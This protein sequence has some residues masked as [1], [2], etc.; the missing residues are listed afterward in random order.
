MTQTGEVDLQSNTKKPCPN[1]DPNITQRAASDPA[2]SVWVGASAGTGKTKVLTD[3]VLR[4]LLPRHDGQEGTPA[5]RILCLTFTKAAANEM[6]IRIHETLARWAIMPIESNDGSKSL[7]AVI[8][9]LLGHRP[10]AEQLNAA[11]CLFAQVIDC[12]GGLKI[13]T[14]HSF[15]QS[16]LGRFPLEAGLSPHFSC[17]DEMQAQKL[18]DQ[19]IIKTLGTA[20]SSEYAGSDIGHA[21]AS[22][23]K[24]VDEQSFN[25][26]MYHICSERSQIEGMVKQYG[27][28]DG[29]YAAICSY[30]DIA[31]GKQEEDMIADAVILDDE[32]HDALKRI[33]VAMHDDKGALSRKNAAP[34]IAWLVSDDQERIA[35]FQEYYNG[36]FTSKG[37][38]RSKSFPPKSVISDC[39]DAYDILHAE[40]M[41]LRRVM[42]KCKRI[43]SAAMTRDVLLLG[44]TILQEYNV[45]K[46]KQSVLDYDDLILYTLNI[47]TGVAHSPRS[48]ESQDYGDVVPW[49]MYKMDRGID[50]ILVDEAQDTNP[51]Q[52]RIIDALCDEFFHGQSARDDVTRTM[53]TVGDIKQSIYSFQRASPQ[54]FQNMQKVV[55]EK[56]TRASQVSNVIDLDVSFRSTTSVLNVVD[57]VFG[58]AVLN[59]AVGGGEIRHH[60]FREGQA[61]EVTLWPLFETQKAPQRVFWDPPV[62]VTEYQSAAIALAQ[63][64]ASQIKGWL[65]G[66]ERLESHDRPIIPG[67]IMILVRTRSAFVDQLVR[68]LK[69]KNI[70][71]S[72]VDRMVL[73]DQL[74]VQDML[75][76]I[77]FCLMP[78]D[79]LNLACLLKTPLLNW[80]E[81]EVFSLCYNR[82]E[83][84]WR[85]LSHFDEGRFSNVSDDIPIVSSTKREQTYQYL[86]HIMAGGRYMGA[87]TFLNHVL[88]MACPADDI[89]AL[90]AIRKRLGEDSLDPLEELLNTALNFPMQY[91]CVDSLQQFLHVLEQ[92]EIVLKREME[93]RGNAVRIMTIHGSKGLQ[94]PIVIMPDTVKSSAAKKGGR[95]LWRNK[96]GVDVPL[97][98]VRK[99][100]DPDMY[101]EAYKKGNTLDEQ[102][103]YRL[104]YVAMTRAA[105][106]LYIGGY[107]GSKGAQPESWYHQI[108]QAMENDQQCIKSDDGLTLTIKNSQTSPPD[109]AKNKIDHAQPSQDLPE[110]VLH[111]VPQEPVPSRP[112]I[113]SRPSE[114]DEEVVMSPLAANTEHRFLRGNLTHKLLQFIPDLD[115]TYRENAARAYVQKNGEE[116]SPESQESIIH[117]LLCILNNDAYAPFFNQNSIA[118]VSVTGA[119]ETG[120]V[121]SGQ[122][123]RLVVE[124]SDVWVIDY[125]T[126]RPPPKTEEDVPEIYHKQMQA[127]KN[128][129]KNIYPNRRIH[130]ALLWTDGPHFMVL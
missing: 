113:P 26:L 66:Q 24:A 10:T 49:V 40:A 4:L 31:Q 122:I 42:D 112:L 54:E 38:V 28:I 56:I 13:M 117:E 20:Q 98:S 78:E 45:L 102:E 81:D 89:S 116:L 64:T 120:E 57:R 82:K 50:H 12:P 73:S 32:Y 107:V 2:S 41:R 15:C 21:F 128:A 19:S 101:Q 69:L 22:L 100:D 3:R 118:E 33:A 110:W 1:I 95:F 52:W 105:D 129:I 23:S 93:G 29:I 60:S 25:Q 39:P 115:H 91:E 84:V 94:A 62:T 5:Q 74:V 108:K 17:L 67:D 11:Q 104:L 130:S 6:A 47:L 75:A 8:E 125:K 92:Q 114:E 76:V 37:D 16:V 34:I 127:Y 51:E 27:S 88:H 80:S 44:F 83:S 86:K 43:R 126:N 103:Y 106:R 30:Y 55:H 119:I 35:K 61:G 97:F 18:L 70:P 36:F 87:Y 71:V 124:E 77:R 46:Q 65:D 90:R 48:G 99:D 68:A 96:T 59:H 58:N 72:G 109:K 79:D 63:H 121:I 53:F 111:P 7:H 14:I 85:E 123:D 9:D